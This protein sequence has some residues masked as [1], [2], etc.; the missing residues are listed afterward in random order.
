MNVIFFYLELNIDKSSQSILKVMLMRILID[1]RHN[2]GI[3]IEFFFFF[4]KKLRNV[5]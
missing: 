4:V 5:V 1:K 2:A 3:C